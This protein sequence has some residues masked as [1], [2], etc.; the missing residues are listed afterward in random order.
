M[1]KVKLPSWLIALLQAI[2]VLAYVALVAWFMISLESYTQP[3]YASVVMMLTLL[4]FSA[5]VTGSLVFGYPVYLALHKKTKEAVKI[6]G[7]TLLYILGLLIIVF[8][9]ISII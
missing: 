2:G 7:L 5:S 8:L 9:L 3:A 1:A 4:V 6:L